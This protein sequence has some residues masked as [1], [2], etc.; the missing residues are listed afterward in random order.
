MDDVQARSRIEP[1]FDIVRRRVR[2]FMTLVS[3]KGRPT[4]MDWIYECRIYGMK[5]RYNTTV[6]C[7]I[8]WEGNRVLY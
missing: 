3:E 7:V 2:R 1:M 4:P 8:E 6:E 5:I